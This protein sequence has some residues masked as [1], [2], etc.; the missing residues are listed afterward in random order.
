MLI[1]IDKVPVRPEPQRWNVKHL[2]A[3]SVFM[4]LFSVAVVMATVSVL[5]V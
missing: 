3:I 5:R 4:G 2:T 1:A